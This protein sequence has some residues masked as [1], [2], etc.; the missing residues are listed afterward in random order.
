M[1]VKP[2]AVAAARL[3]ARFAQASPSR[4]RHGVR[5]RAVQRVW[6]ALS[7]RAGNEQRAPSVEAIRDP[8][9]PD[10]RAIFFRPVVATTGDAYDEEAG[11]MEVVKL[12][13]GHGAKNEVSKSQDSTAS[14]QN[15][16][17][18]R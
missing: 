18:L 7:C 16:A 14:P 5:G 12:L 1:L 6:A 13:L 9:H 4:W 17:S 15:G 3:V 10:F 8:R 11:Y 2:T